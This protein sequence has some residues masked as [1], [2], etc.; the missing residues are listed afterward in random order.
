MKKVLALFAMVLLLPQAKGQLNNW[1]V[2][3][4]VGFSSQNQAYADNRKT[5]S[6]AVGPEIGVSIGENWSTGLVLGLSGS[7]IKDDIGG[8][9]SSFSFMPDIYGRRWW[10]VSE[11]F[12]LFAGLDVIFGVGSRTDYVY[13]QAGVSEDVTSIS[14]LGANLN[15]G[16]AY[17]LAERWT[18]L[19][20]L[21][22]VG[23]D[24]STNGGNTDNTLWLLGDGNVTNSNFLFVGIYWTFL[25]DEKS[26]FE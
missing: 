23:F 10:T 9:S 19:F 18:L 24:S 6:W 15:G 5:L 1:Y 16:V 2:G 11:R 12:K 17:S 21:A 7:D 14:S 4:I 25:P 3:G 22:G 13:S 26:R 8:I 20:K